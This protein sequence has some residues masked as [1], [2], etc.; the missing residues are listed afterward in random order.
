MSK[1][2]KPKFKKNDREWSTF[3]PNSK[4]QVKA[5]GHAYEHNAIEWVENWRYT[6]LGTYS[7]E[8]AQMGINLK[9]TPFDRD[10]EAAKYPLV[11]ELEVGRDDFILSAAQIAEL[12]AIPARD[13]IRRENRKAELYQAW[14]APRKAQNIQIRAANLQ[15]AESLKRIPR[16]T[17]RFRDMYAKI[18][19]DMEADMNEAARDTIRR[20]VVTRNVPDGAARGGAEPAPAAGGVAAGGVAA[21]AAAG[22][23][24]AAVAGAAVAGRQVS[25]SYENARDTRD[26]IWILEAAIHGLITKGADENDPHEMFIRKKELKKKI[27]DF[28]QGSLE[29][30]AYV[31]AMKRLYEHGEHLGLN[32]DETERV[33]ILMGNVNPEI[34]RHQIAMFRDPVQRLSMPHFGSY[35]DLVEALSAVV[36]MT[37]DAVLIR[38][39]GQGRVESS[40]AMHEEVQDARE[41]KNACHICGA[42]GTNFH[43]ARECPLRDKKKSVAENIAY[44]KKNPRALKEKRDKGKQDKKRKR[45]AEKGQGSM[46]VNASRVPNPGEIR[47]ETTMVSFETAQNQEAFQPLEFDETIM[48]TVECSYLVAGSR[49]RGV[50]PS[51]VDFILDTATESSTIRPADS[52]LASNL[53]ADPVS[54]VGV[55]DNAVVSDACGDSIFGQTRVLEMKNNLVSQ[56]QVRQYYKLIE[57]NGDCFE[58]VPRGLSSELPTW[59]FIRDYDRYGDNLLHCTVD[60]RLFAN[61]TGRTVI[62]CLSMIQAEPL[63][64]EKHLSKAQIEILEK[65]E[66]VHDDLNHASAS[67]LIRT[68]KSELERNLAKEYCIGLTVEE[69]NLWNSIRGH[70]CNGCIRGKLT[71]YPH[72]PSTREE[73]YLPGEAAGGDLMFI[74]VKSGASLKPLLVT[75]DCNTQLGTITTMEDKSAE[76]ICAA[77]SL[78]QSNKKSFGRPMKVLYFDR[79]PSVIAKAAWIKET[80]GITIIPKAA[81]QHVGNAERYI[82]TLK[83]TCRATKIGVYDK[84]GYMPPM[85]WNIDLVLDVNSSLNAVVR[86]GKSLSPIELITGKPPDRLRGLRG[87]PWGSIILTKP[88]KRSEAANINEPK[89]EYSVVVRRAWDRSGVLKVYQIQ[90][91]KYAYRLQAKKVATVPEWVLTKLQGINQNAVIGYEDDDGS[92]LAKGLSPNSNEEIDEL[93]ADLESPALDRLSELLDSNGTVD[94]EEVRGLIE[95]VLDEPEYTPAVG[96]ADSNEPIEPT[97]AP[98]PFTSGIESRYPQRDRHPPNRFPQPESY[99]C[100]AMTYSQAFKVRPEKAVK[101]LDTELDNWHR[102]KGWRPVLRENL[103]MEQQRAIIHGLSNFV[104]K[105]DQR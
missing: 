78:D 17:Q 31:R 79:E 16:L 43:F 71:D 41:S 104:E 12:A 50:G 74:E 66:Q 72:K 98:S 63:K 101:A 10:A 87:L 39:Q 27:E 44:F 15:N 52:S 77:L 94:R 13:A 46:P 2:S 76:S 18:F 9:F 47:S 58:L 82:R 24:A 40:F 70:N 97:V 35:D 29:W 1:S 3:A 88:P 92:E 100:Y 30:G 99:M 55:G 22:G 49:R 65:V 21:G 67:T 103:S 42:V 53:R 37:D 54:L 73:S 69:I 4:L 7:E 96:L 95:E 102:A 84:Y 85:S 8:A 23:A 32:L 83:D 59:T 20:T 28:K 11:E 25:I 19:Q 14:A 60:R 33:A 51:Q 56:F 81:G 36:R 38:A 6:K 93:L 5:V 68:V 64:S 86:S 61:T 48:E 90:S 34:F 91:G 105:Y 80:L 26:F 45:E 89:A 57:V 62:E 75:V